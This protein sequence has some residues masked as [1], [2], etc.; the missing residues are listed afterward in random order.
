VARECAGHLSGDFFQRD[1]FNPKKNGILPKIK[2]NRFLY[3][4]AGCPRNV[5]KEGV[6][7][8]KNKEKFTESEHFQNYSLKLRVKL[9]AKAKKVIEETPSLHIFSNIILNGYKVEYHYSFSCPPLE[10][11][12]LLCSRDLMH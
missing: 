6:M 7:E 8:R 4:F 3:S 11:A 5:K 10:C 1:F 12:G 2:Q 9:V